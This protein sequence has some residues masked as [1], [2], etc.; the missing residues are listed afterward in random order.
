MLLSADTRLII[1]IATLMFSYQILYSALFRLV[2]FYFVN[3]AH[4]GLLLEG[5]DL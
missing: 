2:H 1:D 3:C 5:G 4:S